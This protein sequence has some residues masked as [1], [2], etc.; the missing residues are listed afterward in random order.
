MLQD[1]GKQDE[2]LLALERAYEINPEDEDTINSLAVL[3]FRRDD[4]ARA[5]IYCADGI[6]LNPENPQ[7]WNTLGVVYFN[8]QNYEDA[9]IA[10]EHAVMRNPYYY[11]ALFNLRD[12]Y[13]QLG[14]KNGYEECQKRLQELKSME[15]AL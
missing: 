6:L 15:V 11:D 8:Q 2:A 14:N 5:L 13:E 7:F 9:S 4:L 3:C 10:F 1:A 12:T